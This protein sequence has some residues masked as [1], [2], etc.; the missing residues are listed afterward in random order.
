MPLPDVSSSLPATWAQATIVWEHLWSPSLTMS[1]PSCPALMWLHLRPRSFI[2]RSTA[3]LRKVQIF[4]PWK[5]ACK[6]IR[7]SSLMKKGL[8]LAGG[9]VHIL[10]MCSFLIITCI[11]LLQF[12]RLSSPFMMFWPWREREW[13]RPGPARTWG[14]T[15]RSNWLPFAARWQR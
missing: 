9:Y 12:T 4:H 7:I 1:T 11:D 5:W 2:R 14:R 3:F 6:G 10:V 8:I 15:R 13:G